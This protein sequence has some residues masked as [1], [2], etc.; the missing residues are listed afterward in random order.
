MTLPQP[1]GFQSPN[2]AKRATLRGHL[3]DLWRDA[4]AWRLLAGSSTALLAASLATAILAYRLEAPSPATLVQAL[5]QQVAQSGPV[6]L[7]LPALSVAPTQMP[8][9]ATETPASH[10]GPSLGDPA[11]SFRGGLGSGGEGRIIGFLSQ[12]KASSLIAVTQQRTGARINPDY[13]SNPRAIISLPDGRKT[14]VL[15][16]PSLS[17]KPGDRVAY[18]SGH[19]DW[20]MACGYIP[21]LVIGLLQGN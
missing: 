9:S 15:L 4:P 7:H 16:P 13:V 1:L 8:P 20:S 14:V 10:A 19:R 3:G 12:E 11:C 2:P 18:A 17:A 6:A 21:N 5:P